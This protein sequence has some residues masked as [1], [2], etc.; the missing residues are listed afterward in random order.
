MYKIID[1]SIGGS[2]GRETSEFL[3]QTFLLNGSKAS[4]PGV[5][6]NSNKKEKKTK[7][8]NK[9]ND[10]DNNND[11]S[12]MMLKNK[13]AAIHRNTKFLPGHYRPKSNVARYKSN[14]KWLYFKKIIC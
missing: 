3:I 9:S 11:A 14:K 13:I 1:S 2:F 5:I 7:M 10:N 8:N 6:N 4:L 12:M